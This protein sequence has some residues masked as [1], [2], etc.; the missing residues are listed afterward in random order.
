MNCGV[1][2]MK[3]RRS[4]EIRNAEDFTEEE[5]NNIKQIQPEMKTD[6]EENEVKDKFEQESKPECAASN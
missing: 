2:K 1:K 4:N 6:G 5:L 3:L